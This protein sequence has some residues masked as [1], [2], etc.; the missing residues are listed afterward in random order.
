EGLDFNNFAIL[1]RANSHA[2]PFITE[3][4][5][6]EIPYIFSGA[7][8]LYQRPEVRLIISFVNVLTNHLDN[9]S[10]YHL[11]TSEIYKVNPDELSSINSYLRRHNKSFRDIFSNLDFKVREYMSDKT[12][13]KLLK[14]IEDIKKFSDLIPN[15]NTGELLYRFVTDTGFIKRL[16][17]EETP[18]SEVKVQNIAK[19][20]ERIGEFQDASFDK[21]IMKFKESLD[22]LLEAEEDPS[23]AKANQDINAVNLLTVHKSKGLE[24]DVVFVA[25]CVNGRFPGRKRGETISI[26]SELIKESLPDGDFHIQEERRLFYVAMTRAK[27]E[28]ILTSATSYG[29]VRD[30][31]ISQ[32]I[33]ESLD[34]PMIAKKKHT[35][36]SEAFIE[37]FKKQDI[38]E[39]PETFFSRDGRLNLSPHQLDDYISCPLKFKYVN[40]L[41]VPVMS[42]H[43]VHYGTA[44]HAAVE[45][46]F[47]KKMKKRPITLEEIWEAFE[48]AW[49]SEGYITREHEE[50]R[51]RAGREALRVFYEHEKAQDKV[52]TKIEDKFSFTLEADSGPV[53]MNGRYD[54]VYEQGDRIEIVDFK[55]S[56]VKEQEKADSRAKQSTQLAIYAL[57]YFEMYGKNPDSVTLYFV[58]SGLKGVAKKTEKDFEKLKKSINDVAGKIRDKKFNAKPSY[59]ECGICAYKDIC[60]YT[61]TKI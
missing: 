25:N 53:R 57:S 9:L 48:N 56:D 54:A 29:G 15:H 3:L 28:L 39:L 47:L 45:L 27:K 17:K 55:T 31:K 33:A 61:E 30:S 59:T 1:Y 24:F 58:D 38:D 23:A 7:S 13:K 21:S 44:V 12:A 51:I 49:V 52:P 18:E 36:D 19:F 40:I 2:E 35:G 37:K 50:E 60:P 16:L 22:L 20:F 43:A 10:F 34:E 14:I 11:A 5:A 42:Y 32:F 8:G 41:K 46:Y 6:K 26:P 4:K